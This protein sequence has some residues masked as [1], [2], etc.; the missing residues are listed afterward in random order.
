MTPRVRPARRTLGWRETF[1]LTSG[2]AH[3][4]TFGWCYLSFC[5]MLYWA[6]KLLPRGSYCS[7]CKP[8]LSFHITKVTRRATSYCTGTNREQGDQP[9]RSGD[10]IYFNFFKCKLFALTSVYVGKGRWVCVWGGKNIKWN[11]YGA[12]LWCAEVT[13]HLRGQRKGRTRKRVHQRPAPGFVNF[14]PTGQNQSSPWLQAIR[15][16]TWTSSLRKAPRDA[17]WTTQLV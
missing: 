5:H 3:I 17:Q 9:N 2:P 4:H 1:R 7:K 10:S 16:L 12:S 15:M 6:P 14:Q 8:F 13:L 11:L